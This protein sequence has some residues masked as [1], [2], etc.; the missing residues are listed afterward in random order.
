MSKPRFAFHGINKGGE[1]ETEGTDRKRL[2]LPTDNNFG[3]PLPSP[4]SDC[5][6]AFDHLSRKFRG[7]LS[8]D[9]S[10]RPNPVCIYIYTRKLGEGMN[11]PVKERIGERLGETYFSLLCC[12]QSSRIF[13]LVRLFISSLTLRK[14]NRVI[15]NERHP[16]RE[17]NLSAVVP[18]F[19]PFQQDSR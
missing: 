2:L 19:H 18:F 10:P 17:S 4:P 16:Y 12:R 11:P 3:V 6:T 15:W 8:L 5:H 9:P 14:A 1:R 13:L 7:T